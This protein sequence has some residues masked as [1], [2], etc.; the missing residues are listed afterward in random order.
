MVL[1]VANESGV[2]LSLGFRENVLVGAH[3]VFVGLQ[4]DGEARF[5]TE[6]L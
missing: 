1:L 2:V 6:S 3:M 4:M 5:S